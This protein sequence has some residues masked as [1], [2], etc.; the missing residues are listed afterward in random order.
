MNC[1]C[2]RCG[3]AHD[4][5]FGSGRFCSRKC[6]STLSPEKAKAVGAKNR[7]R[8]LGAASPVKGR[9]L[10]PQGLKAK[11]IITERVTARWQTG[12][13]EQVPPSRRRDRLLLEQSGKC[14]ICSMSQEWMGKYLPFEM[15]HVSGDRT[16]N[17]RINLRM[18]CPNCHR[19]T[20]TWGVGNVSDDGKR[21]MAES[22][23]K[24]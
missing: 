16:D 23:R 7:E 15:D 19:Q 2:E 8:M 9:K 10:G 18:I 14:A 1:K 11:Q 13:W 4:G 22:K 17:S 6:S 5:S 21:R 12:P 20:D 3:L 24:K